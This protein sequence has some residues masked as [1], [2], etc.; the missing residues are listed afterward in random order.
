[1]SYHKS[2]EELWNQIRTRLAEIERFRPVVPPAPTQWQQTGLSSRI[3]V[4]PRTAIPGS[5]L[6]VAT[7][8]CLAILVVNFGPLSRREP[9][10][11]ASNAVVP[12]TPS[13]LDTGI[14]VTLIV[15]GGPGPG[16][17]ASSFGTLTISLDQRVVVQRALAPGASTRVPL[18]ASRYTLTATYG[19]VTCQSLSVDVITG[20]FTP[21][22]LTCS[23]R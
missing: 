23:I 17:H 5:L 6:A 15:A 19:N 10:V 4:R 12:S 20:Q 1:M 8:V 16:I 11:A 21:V 13:A 18:A 14:D 7:I 3:L 22:S 9:V 2:D